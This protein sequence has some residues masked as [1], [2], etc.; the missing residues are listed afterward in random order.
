MSPFQSVNGKKP[1]SIDIFKCIERP[2]TDL[3]YL[4]FV[5]AKQGDIIGKLVKKRRQR[6]AIKT[7]KLP[8]NLTI[9]SVGYLLSILPLFPLH[10]S[11]FLSLSYNER[12]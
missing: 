8:T 6:E 10:F 11:F 5:S 4:Q 1:E 12:W 9:T 2:L 3:L 7:L